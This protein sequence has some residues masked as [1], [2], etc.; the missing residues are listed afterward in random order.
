[1]KKQNT[2][3]LA[4]QYQNE[5]A[6]RAHIESIHWPDGPICSH[7]GVLDDATKL[8]PREGSKNGVRKGVWNCNSCREQFTVTIGTIFEDSHIP[9]HK[10]LLAIHLMASSKKGI[11][12]LQLMRNLE[13]GSYRTAWFMAHR[14][15]WALTQEPIKGALQGIVEIDETYVGGKVKGHGVKAGK[16]NKTPVVSLVERGGRA[17]SY[18][19]ERV[20][21]RNLR[22]IIKEHVHGWSQVM[23]DDAAIYPHVL[24]GRVASHDV[25]NHSKDE[26]VRRENGKC[27]TTNSVESFFAI[28]KRGHYGIYHHWDRKYMGQYLREYD[29]RYNVRGFPDIERTVIAL[30]MTVGKRMRLKPPENA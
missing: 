26:Y 8:E 30:K 17:R 22:P 18:Q 3:L 4:P 28:L 11:S 16:D 2:G 24:K 23:T 15:R 13:I 5:D 1:M 20:N 21:A 19:V 12:A 27:V 29:W 7:C 14:I 6:A 9:L 10:W 25:V